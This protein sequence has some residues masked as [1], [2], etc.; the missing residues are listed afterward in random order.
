V[1]SLGRPTVSREKVGLAFV[2]ALYG[3]KRNARGG[4]RH[5]GNVERITA[6]VLD[7]DGKDAAY[8]AAQLRKALRRWKFIAYTTWQHTPDCPRW[9]VIIPLSE[10]IP[11]TRQREALARVEALTGL[12]TDKQCSDPTRLYFLPLCPPERRRFFRVIS[13]GSRRFLRPADLLSAAASSFSSE[14]LFH[15]RSSSSIG[16]STTSNTTNTLIPH[17]FPPD[18]VANRELTGSDVEAIWRE[19]GITGKRKGWWVPEKVLSLSALHQPKRRGERHSRIFAYTR[20]LK[21]YEIGWEPHMARVAFKA[22]WRNARRIVGTKDERTSF[23]DFL[24]AWDVVEM[25]VGPLDVVR[26]RKAAED[27]QLPETAA[28]LPELD[29]T[30]LAACYVLQRANDGGLFYLTYE[31]AGRLLGVAKA[32]ARRAL[33]RLGKAISARPALLK[34]IEIGN[35]YQG[36]ASVYAVLNANKLAVEKKPLRGRNRQ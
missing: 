25:P 4:L 3:N 13:G 21:G 24:D 9:R 1:V 16:R 36:K 32:T 33:L 7:L 34:R 35:N 12:K 20:A 10:P 23:L 15:C 26:L 18:L 6:L 2:P 14:A 5:N 19:R 29:R 31:D 30:L 22:W 17:R 8:T 27:E 11:P 28:G